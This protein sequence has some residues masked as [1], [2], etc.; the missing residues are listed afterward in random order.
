MSRPEPTWLRDENGEIDYAGTARAW[1]NGTHP[2]QVAERERR[3]AIAAQEDAETPVKQPRDTRTPTS[4]RLYHGT[5]HIFAPGEM[6]EP[7][8]PGSVS[9]I[10]NVDPSWKTE[11]SVYTT[12]S[13]PEAQNYAGMRASSRF[14]PVYE[15]NNDTSHSVYDLLGEDPILKRGGWR[16]K[17]TN[18]HA[19]HQPLEPRAIVGWGESPTHTHISPQ[20]SAAMWAMTS[21]IGAKMPDEFK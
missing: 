7:R 16:N 8:S 9:A 18:T 5:D 17:Y 13:Y 19:S 11:K 10:R 20:F 6:I 2:D 1:G 4:T 15:T 21:M 3:A 14:A 12:S